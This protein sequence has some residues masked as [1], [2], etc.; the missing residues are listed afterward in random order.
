MSNKLV[1]FEVNNKDK[2]NI[3]LLNT[4]KMLS[5]RG[6]LDK[7]HIE[8]RYAEIKDKEPDELM[9]D[10]KMDVGNNFIVKFIFFKVNTVTK[11]ASILETLLKLKNKNKIIIVEDINKKIYKQIMLNPDIEIFWHHELMINIIDHVLVPEHTAIPL[12]YLPNH[13]DPEGKYVNSDKFYDIYLTT[14]ALCP[15]IEV[16]DPIARYYKYVPGQIIQIKR[17]SL[18]SGYTISYRVVINASINKLFDR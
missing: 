12:S 16:I 8:T 5:S 2:I 15:K 17:P 9:F 7:K 1:A 4:L 13:L 18:T 6:L 14:T 11:I 3:V 10:I